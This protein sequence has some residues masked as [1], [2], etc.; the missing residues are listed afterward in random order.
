MVVFVAT[1]DLPGSDVDVVQPVDPA[2][3]QYGVN[4]RGGHSEGA[5]DPDGSEA[6]PPTER[7]DL[8]DEV[9]AGAVR[10]AVGP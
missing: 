2:P 9:R 10:G 4:G 3:G 5:S 6:F 7:D 1:N 8:P